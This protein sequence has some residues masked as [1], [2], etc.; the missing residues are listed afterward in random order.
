[1]SRARPEIRLERILMALGVE[2]AA[3]TDEEV[4]AAAADLGMKPLM[5]GTAAFFGLKKLLL[6]YDPEK[7]AAPEAE[8]GFNEW[9]SEPSS[10]PWKRGPTD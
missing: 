10:A 8:W 1:M 9:E 3:A 2:V 7:L 6:P 5:Q 4:L